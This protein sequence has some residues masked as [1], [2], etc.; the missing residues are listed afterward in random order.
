MHGGVF[1][2]ELNQSTGIES[3]NDAGLSQELSKEKSNS[4]DFV[5]LHVHTGY[6]LL[7][8]A[9]RVSELVSRTRELGMK[10]LAITDHG[11][12]FGVIHFYLECQK[13]GIH[14]IIGCE[15]YVAPTSR[16]DKEKSEDHTRYNHL[17]LLA[18]NNTGYKNLMKLVTL[19]YTEGFYSKPR[20]D[21]ELMEKCHEGLI[22]CSAC[23]AGIIPSL[24]RRDLYEE[25]K[26]EALRFERIFGHGNFFLELQDHG[27]P[28]Q[29]MVNQG[30]MRLHQELGIDLIATNDVHYILEEDAEAHDV[31][32][33]VQT[34]KLVTDT[35]RMKYEPRQF[36]LKSPEQMASVFPYAPEALANTVK[37]AER[38][39]VEIDI[40]NRN[41]KLPRFDVPDGKTASEYL[42]ELC[43]DGLSKRYGDEAKK[44]A[45]KL[46]SELAVIE[47][48]GF[49]DYFLIVWDFIRY[50]REH[51]I[52]VG[53]GRGSAA[54]SLVAYTLWITDL[55]DP[56]RYQLIFERFL[57]PER[58][59]MP[60]IDVD[61]EPEGREEVINYVRQKYGPDHVAQIIAIGTLKS[62]AV[63]SDVGR[64]FGIPVQYRMQVTKTIPQFSSL[65]DGLKESPDFREY[66][67]NDDQIKTVV[68]I[69]MRLEGLPRH[70][71]KHAAGVLIA[72]EPVLNY[73]PL[74]IPQEKEE[75]VIVTQ[76]E[77]PL[78][79][80]QGLLK[81][82]FL[83]L[84]NLTVIR[85]A[86]EGNVEDMR[87]IDYDDPKVFELISSGRTSGIFQLESEGMTNF[88]KRLKPDCIED[89]IAGISLYRPGP[90]DFIPQ[91]IEGKRNQ[92]KITY[93]IPELEP[94][95]K[96][97][98]GC[99]V[100]QEQVMQ[101]VRDLAGYSY[102]GSDN[103]R[104]AMSKKKLEVMLKERERFVHGDPDEGIRGCVANGIPEEA[105][106]QLWDQMMSFAAYAFNKS[107]AAAYAMVAYQTAYLKCHFPFHFMAAMMTSYMESTDKFM[108]YVAECKKEG[109]RILPPDVNRSGYRF[110]ADKETDPATGK[111]EDVIRYGLVALKGIGGTV[112]S[113][114]VSE[115]E[116]NGPYQSLKDLCM[117]LPQSMVNKKTIEALIKSGA[118]DS[119]PG[120]RLQKMHVHTQV[121]DSVNAEKKTRMSGQ[122]SL[123]DMMEDMDEESQEVLD[124][125][126]PNVGEYEKSDLLAFEK[127]IIGF[128]VSGHPLEE[129]L[130]YLKQFV[131]RY[132][133]DFRL[134][135]EAD[136]L[137]AVRDREEAVIA[138][139]VGKVTVKNTRNGSIMAFVTLEDMTGEVEVII[140]P[141]EYERF[142]TLLVKEKKLMIRGRVSPEEDKDAK[143]IASEISCFDE[144][145]QMLWVQFQTVED[146]REHE[147]ELLERIDAYDGSDLVTV[148]I[149]E[150]KKMKRLPPS[151][152]TKICDG[153][154]AD[155]K[156]LYGE[157]SVKVAEV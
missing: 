110:M 45:H 26:E 49:V 79:E 59:T 94:I 131:T 101:I 90:M 27:M 62:R 157:D 40:G 137:P 17:I 146:Y 143:L 104:R 68:D 63:V 126:F 48:M 91:Y 51:G 99:I 8:G 133:V 152:S 136:A 35:D 119:L 156:G 70:T 16:F 39:Q 95:L 147:K 33:C 24:L 43:H 118:M 111:E 139:I 78:L 37:I 115:R 14:P 31:L 121:I 36:F 52:P 13:Q 41:Y 55:V 74:A 3:T 149:R 18:E 28:E 98:Y 84:R 86:A 155:L 54:G 53:P 87:A 142:R 83:G 117:R 23:L 34:R 21:Y 85:D 72:P 132:A 12:M 124:I 144:R 97:T 10:H 107:H 44:Y 25:A 5:H 109:I 7:D 2:I 32:I 9:C 80:E 92:D 15:V 76:Y 140:F 141:R 148:V 67:E 20:I 60:D 105:A 57:N 6:S 65:K 29:K 134:P 64:A 66:Y 38:C 82:D 123:F 88:M 69:A 81:M 71:T 42:R 93:L 19:G 145:P 113:E 129:D 46:E 75:D 150:G 1:N 112:V 153:L 11:N 22:C 116:K 30:L 106:N 77:A 122:L 151:H 58:V 96:P 138:G 50:A 61:F 47:E 102:G 103:V 114:L 127:E 89:L 73:V 100:Y 4:A 154:L 56:I 130:S 120:T 135:E 128:Y 125:T 108:R